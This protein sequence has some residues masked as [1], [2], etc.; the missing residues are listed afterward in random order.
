M[1]FIDGNHD[2]HPK[3]RRRRNWPAEIHY[4]KRGT[5]WIFVND[6]GRDVVVSFLG[7]AP[8]I[9][10]DLR[11]EGEDWW[12]EEEIKNHELP[13]IRSDVLITHDAPER[14]HNL[15]EIPLSMSLVYKCQMS[16]QMIQEAVRM[17]KPRV[18]YHGHY[19]WPYKSSFEGTEVR[20]VSCNRRPGGYVVVNHNF[21]E[22]TDRITGWVTK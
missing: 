13:W 12:P 1:F 10:K 6:D 2:W 5:H 22:V 4:C 20:G 8:S 11:I 18:L 16:W 21:E 17:T 3:L 15:A 14:P 9:D 19:H 7:G